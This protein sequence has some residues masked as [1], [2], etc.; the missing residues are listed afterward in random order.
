[1]QTPAVWTL[2]KLTS[3]AMGRV[4][5]RQ[6]SGVYNKIHSPGTHGATVCYSGLH[7][8]A[9]AACMSRQRDCWAACEL[10]AYSW[11]MFMSPCRWRRAF[12]LLSLH[13][14]SHCA[15]FLLW[16]CILEKLIAD[17][18]TTFWAESC[19]VTWNKLVFSGGWFEADYLGMPHNGAE[20][21]RLLPPIISF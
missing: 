14:S 11:F 2:N 17:S 12:T 20:L 4:Y 3:K 21:L 8:S 6:V 15:W 13:S 7:W 1:M 18:Q 10:I 9:E 19:G 5:R 16:P